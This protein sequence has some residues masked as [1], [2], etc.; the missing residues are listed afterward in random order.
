M[1]KY[2]DI[3]YIYTFVLVHGSV[4]TTLYNVSRTYIVYTHLSIPEGVT[5]MSMYSTDYVLHVQLLLIVVQPS[6]RDPVGPCRGKCCVL[7]AVGNDSLYVYTV[8]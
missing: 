5:H 3:Y 4:P 8:V 6:R 2:I 1:Y 7:L